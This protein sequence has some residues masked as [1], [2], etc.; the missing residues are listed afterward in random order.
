MGT[1]DNDH[2]AFL[3]KIEPGEKKDIRVGYFIADD[4]LDECKDLYLDATNSNTTNNENKIY[5]P[6][7]GVSKEKGE[8]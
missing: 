6:I 2:N 3:L 5:Y 7:P 4:F 8:N 1:I